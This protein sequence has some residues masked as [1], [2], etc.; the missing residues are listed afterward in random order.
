MD[1]DIL[2]EDMDVILINKPK[3][4]VVHPAARSLFTHTGK[5]ADVSLQGPAFRY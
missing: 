5:R 1:L 4:M 3:G 2:Y